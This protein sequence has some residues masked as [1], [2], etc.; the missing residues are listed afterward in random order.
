MAKEKHVGVNFFVQ[1][2][3]AMRMSAA[4]D[5]T[6]EYVVYSRADA[7]YTAAVLNAHMEQVAADDDKRLDDEGVPV[8]FAV[9]KKF[10][11][12]DNDGDGTLEMNIAEDGDETG[13]F[14]CFV[15]AGDSLA[16]LM[17]AAWMGENP[18]I[19]RKR[20]GDGT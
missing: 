11:F 18:V 1:A 4:M 7:T 9:L 17:R 13:T 20:M 3:A 8:W 10:K 15:E 12:G 2:D 6:H 14:V 5:D 16:D 19:I